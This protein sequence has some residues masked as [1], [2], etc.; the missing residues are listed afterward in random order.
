[1][2]V[3]PFLK[4][5]RLQSRSFHILERMEAPGHHLVHRTFN[6]A[7]LQAKLAARFRFPAPTAVTNAGAVRIRTAFF[8]ST[9]P[10]CASCSSS[11]RVRF[12]SIASS[13]RAES[14]VATR[15]LLPSVSLSSCGLQSS[16]APRRSTGQMRRTWIHGGDRRRCLLGIASKRRSSLQRCVPFAHPVRVGSKAALPLLSNAS[17]CHSSSASLQSQW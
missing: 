8:D 5:A 14:S 16:A 11:R 17:R 7:S 15:M 2:P 1:M 4:P 10:A 9:H 6:G 13:P 3:D 12:L